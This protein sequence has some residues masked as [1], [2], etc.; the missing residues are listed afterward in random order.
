M[1]S[2]LTIRFKELNTKIIEAVGVLSFELG[3]C[4]DVSGIRRSSRRCV[5]GK[6]AAEHR[7]HSE[8]HCKS[9]E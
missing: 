1:V 6:D 8:H 2:R 5:N 7:E 3:I 4:L 9:K